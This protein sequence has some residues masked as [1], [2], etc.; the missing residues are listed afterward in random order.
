MGMKNACAA[1]FT[2]A[3]VVGIQ[4]ALFAQGEL[5]G[6][7][8]FGGADGSGVIPV[9]LFDS[10]GR[11]SSLVLEKRDGSFGANV[12]LLPPGIYFLRVQS[13]DTLR[14]MKFMKK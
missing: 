3:A 2:L 12:Q 13:G 10:Q 8:A 9:Q 1:L 5:W 7:T 4:S 14:Q 6:M 11:A